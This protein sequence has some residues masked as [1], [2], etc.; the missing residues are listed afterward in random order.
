MLNKRKGPAVWGLRA[1]IDRK[2]YKKHIQQELFKN[3]PNLEILE[4]PVEDLIISD[5]NS[6]NKVVKCK[7]IILGE[8]NY[9]VLTLL[10]GL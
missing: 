10:T 9:S 6:S 2:L 7:G 1:Q 4:A 3:T 5:N 8:S